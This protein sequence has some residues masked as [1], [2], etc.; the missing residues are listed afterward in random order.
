[1]KFAF[2]SIINI[3][4]H[5]KPDSYLALASSQVRVGQSDGNTNYSISMTDRPICTRLQA[6]DE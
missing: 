3:L 4:T 6:R 1:M 2:Y 5:K